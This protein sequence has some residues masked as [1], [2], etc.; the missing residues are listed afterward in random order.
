MGICRGWGSSTDWSLDGGFGRGGSTIGEGYSSALLPH[1]LPHS[2]DQ[3]AAEVSKC[4]SVS[5]GETQIPGSSTRCYPVLTCT[6]A[7]QKYRFGNLAAGCQGDRAMAQI[8]GGKP[9]SREGWVVEQA[10]GPQAG[11]QMAGRVEDK[12]KVTVR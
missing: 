6:A 1:L 11:R 4:G 10:A 12:F 2:V 9:G 7:D 5:G 8:R 3:V